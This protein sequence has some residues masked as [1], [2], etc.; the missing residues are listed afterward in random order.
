MSY[1]VNVL[2]R[3]SADSDIIFFWIVKRS[4]TGAARWQVA[5]EAAI[6]SL[7]INPEQHHLAP[8]AKRLSEDIRELHFRTQNGRRYRLLFV[9]VG[10]E[11][12]VLSVRGA[13][14]PPITADDLH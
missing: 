14:Q 7:A 10:N 9:V 12:R 1:V 5:L 3:A 11:V 8:E 2:S 4:R 13:G 6:D